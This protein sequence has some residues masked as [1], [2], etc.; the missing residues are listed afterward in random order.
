MEVA[1]TLPF[2]LIP[3]SPPLMAG[4][5]AKRFGRN[6]WTWF[7]ISIPLPLISCFILVCLPDKSKLEKPA[8]KNNIL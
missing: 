2:L 6:F 3:L 8:K 5:V 1:F 7:F 4:Y